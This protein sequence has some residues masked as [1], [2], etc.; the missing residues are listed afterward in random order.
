MTINKTRGTTFQKVGVF[1]RVYS[2]VALSRVGSLNN[3]IVAI[4]HECEGTTRN[5]VYEGIFQ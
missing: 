5:V 2:T 4:N 1:L 3:I